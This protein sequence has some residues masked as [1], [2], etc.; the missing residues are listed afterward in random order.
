MKPQLLI[1]DTLDDRRELHGLL[2]RLPPRDRIRF[3]Q[4]CCARVPRG[5]DRL[6]VPAVWSMRATVDQAYRDDRADLRLTN[7]IYA[8]VLQLFNQYRLDAVATALL[9]TEWV[10]RPEARRVPLPSP[11]SLDRSAS[12]SPLA[13][14]L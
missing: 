5:S 4:T 10:R 12:P 1:I 13:L 7:E 3:L 9:L 8:D 14:P 2:H 11:I 6:P